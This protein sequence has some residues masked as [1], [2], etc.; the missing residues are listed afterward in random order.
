MEEQVW[1]QSLKTYFEENNEDK[2]DISWRVI[3]I[4]MK[5]RRSGV[6]LQHMR[7]HF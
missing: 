3:S 2:K 7:I 6:N 5:L 4:E 1:E